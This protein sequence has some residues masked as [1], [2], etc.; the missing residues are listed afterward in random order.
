MNYELTIK[1]KKNDNI[2]F[3]VELKNATKS[4]IL[5]FLQE[6]AKGLKTKIKIPFDPFQTKEI[7]NADDFQMKIVN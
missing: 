4:D 2:V 5:Y 7:S 3:T 6:L 1:D